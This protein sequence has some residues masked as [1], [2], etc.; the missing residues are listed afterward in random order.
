MR[1]TKFTDYS[2][3]VLL[4]AAT[5]KADQLTT[6]EETSRLYGI[7]R[8]H[9]KKV[10]LQLIHDGFLEGVR[11]RSGGFRLARLPDQINLGQVL[12]RTE[13]D[14]GLAECFLPD[15][16]CRITMGCRLPGLMNKALLNFL[17][18][19]DAYTL[20]DML[21]DPGYFGMPEQSHY[22]QR[23]PRSSSLS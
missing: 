1:L 8:A 15:N 2:L 12:R 21:I 16:T 14:F 3:R 20:A 13:P 6:I 11:G 17:A 9:L 7:S 10:V 19:F 5:L 23:G 4:Y 18:T 22:P